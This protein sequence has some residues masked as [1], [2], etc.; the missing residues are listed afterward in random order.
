MTDQTS[1]ERDVRVPATPDRVWEVVT[2]P[3]WLSE[4]VQLELVPGG[5]ARF[6][7]RTGWVEEA[8]APGEDPAGVGRLIFWWSRG[9]EPASRVELTLAPEGDA[10]TRL[11]VVESRPLE[12]LDLTGIPLPGAGGPGGGGA[13]PAEGARGPELLLAA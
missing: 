1:I 11:R 3:G 12:A 2:G 6:D 10:H 8:R 7:D 4:D 5:E 13:S 9:A